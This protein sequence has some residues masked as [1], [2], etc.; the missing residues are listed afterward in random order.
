MQS[1]SGESEG[2]F[3]S[4][5]AQGNMEMP[6]EGS[7]RY[8]QRSTQAIINLNAIEHNITEIRKRVGLKRD[9]LAVVKA[10]GYGHGAIE[11]G[12]VALRSGANCLGVALPEE[13][14]QL[15][16]A[17]IDVPILVLGLIQPEEASK[18]VG[19][20][21]GQNIGSLEIAEALSQEAGKATARGRVPTQDEHGID[22]HDDKHE[23]HHHPPRR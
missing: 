11:V 21:L 5:V 14:G 15:R 23:A 2:S 6:E 10:N 8:A 17:G 4:L 3:L 22:F 19:F 13:G 7:Q 12:Q 18:V 1:A 16:Q 20:R 9:L